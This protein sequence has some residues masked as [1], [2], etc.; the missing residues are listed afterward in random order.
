VSGIANALQGDFGET[1]LEA[2]AAGCGLL[3]GRPT[4]LDLEKADIE[5]TLRGTVL[6]TTNPTVKVQVKTEI[7]LLPNSDGIFNYRLDIKTYNVLRL[8]NHAV[9]RVLVVIGLVPGDLKV[10]LHNEGTLLIGRGAW[11]SLEGM[12]T[13]ANTGS[14]LVQLPIT[15]A[16][17]PAGLKRM[18]STYG[19]RSS[20]P[21]PV[22][23][24]WSTIPDAEDTEGEPR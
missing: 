15:N 5:L 23:D 2:V 7:G 22:V 13:S 10:K 3:H 20:T 24:L 4:S 16:I 14:E 1:W 9:R 18:L 6:G 8:E 12:P 21:V 11:V 19:V 17:D